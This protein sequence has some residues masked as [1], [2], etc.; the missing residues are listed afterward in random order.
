V[1]ALYVDGAFTDA[2]SVDQTGLVGIVLDK[3][4][5]DLFVCLR[6]AF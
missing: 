5:L 1:V 2:L 4:R 3:V 6:A